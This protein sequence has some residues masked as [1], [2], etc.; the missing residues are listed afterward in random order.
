[1]KRIATILFPLIFLLAG[2]A[3]ISQQPGNTLFTFEFEDNHYE[4]AGYTDEDGE[5]ANFLI[6]RDNDRILLRAI[7][8]SQTGSIDNVMSGPL[9]LEEANRIY[10][11]GLQIAM[12]M[13]RFKE[14]EKRR[15][16]E[17]TTDEY[18]LV[19]ESFRSE[20]HH[21]QNRFKIYDL[22]RVLLGIYWDINSDGVIDRTKKGDLNPELVNELY[23][24]TL[25]RADEDNRLKS[26]QGQLIITQSEDELPDEVMTSVH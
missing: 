23:S 13:D 10:L 6:Q 25:Q 9:S 7:D 12:D 5:T 4:I 20:R 8:H 1:M 21:F 22:N 17:T 15:I 18:R 3:L 16:F 14:I 24:L 11:A 26:S 2:C 19:V